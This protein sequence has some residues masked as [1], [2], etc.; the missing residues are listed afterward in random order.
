[1]LEVGAWSRL[2]HRAIIILGKATIPREEEVDSQNNA[3]CDENS[4]VQL[5]G[6]SQRECHPKFF[7]AL[8][9]VTEM[10]PPK[11]W[12]ATLKLAADYNILWV[13]ASHRGGS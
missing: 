9:A 5:S 4:R 13:D 3:K 2:Q 12:E 7:I 8:Q 6:D 10:T 11:E 1:M